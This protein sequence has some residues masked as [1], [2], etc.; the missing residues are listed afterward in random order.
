MLPAQIAD[1]PEVAPLDNA[2][3]M[4]ARHR[5]AIPVPAGAVSKTVCKVC[6]A[7]S[8]SFWFNHAA[9][10]MI[11]TTSTSPPLL[12]H[13]PTTKH[14]NMPNESRTRNKGAKIGQKKE[15]HG[16]SR[17]TGQAAARILRRHAR[18]G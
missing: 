9:C 4:Q 6:L 3:Q 1:G 17:L 2:Q 13:S 18:D 14:L 8:R 15:K 11:N 7:P 5:L 12:R 10:F 16:G